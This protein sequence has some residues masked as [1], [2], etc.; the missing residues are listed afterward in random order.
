MDRA[1]TALARANLYNLLATV[2]AQPPSA[3]LARA[4]LDGTLAKALRD[5][6][7][8]RLALELEDGTGGCDQMDLLSYLEVEYAR[9]F[10]VP[11][12]GHVPPYQSM[13]SEDRADQAEADGTQRRRLDKRHLWGNCAVAAQSMYRRAGL[14]LSGEPR[15]VPDHIAMELQFMHHLCSREAEALNGNRVEVAAE[16]ERL[17]REF[18]QAHLIPWVGRFCEA[19]TNITRHPLYKA[20]ADLTL[21][22]VAREAEELCADHRNGYL[23]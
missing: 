9:L 2:Y 20:M 16:S 19:V 21:A 23:A 18:L 12:P 6:G 15:E 13:F 4:I 11:G 5:A 14:A 10:V 17:Q 1:I 22:V 7:L 8:D 3:D